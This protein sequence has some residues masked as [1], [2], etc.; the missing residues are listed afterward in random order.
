MN[1]HRSLSRRTGQPL[2]AT[3]SA[4]IQSSLGAN[5]AGAADED[6]FMKSFEDVPAV[7]LYTSRDLEQELTQIQAILN[8]KNVD[9]E[10]RSEALRKF[11]SVMVAGGLGFDNFLPILKGMECSFLSSLKDLRSKVVREACITVAYLSMK[12]GNKVERFTEALLPTLFVL[13]P[14]SAKIMS[15]SAIVC[16]RFIIQYTHGPRL[17]PV[18][19]YNMTSK[20]KDIR[21][22]TCEFLYQLLN[23]WS[24][25]SLEKH[26]GNL[27][28]A[29]K[30][31]ISDADSEARALARKAFWR[32]SDHFKHQSDVLL[33]SLDH[34][35]QKM[36]LGEQVSVSKPNNTNY[37]VNAYLTN[38]HLYKP[39]AS[40][41]NSMTR[42]VTSSNSIENL[43][44]PTSSLS[45]TV[46]RNKSGIPVFS[47]KDEKVLSR[48]M[49]A[50]FHSVSA[51]DEGAVRR[52]RARA[53]I[54]A[55]MQ[56][57]IASYVLPQNTLS[58]Q[59]LDSISSISSKI[60]S[61][62]RTGRPRHRVSQSQPNSR[63]ASPSAYLSY[64]NE[65]RGSVRV[66]RKSGIPQLMS[67]E[68]SPCSALN[69]SPP[70]FTGLERRISNGHATRDRDSS[71]TRTT[72]ET[73]S[74]ISSANLPS[75]T[76][77]ATS[78]LIAKVKMQQQHSASKPDAEADFADLF[79]VLLENMTEEESGIIRA[80]A[81]RTMC[82]LLMQQTKFF[83][84]YVE[85]II[86]RILEASKD[87]EKEVQRASEVCA[88]TA[89]AV[90]PP[91]QCARVL[92][93]VIV[94]AELP[95]NLAAIKML[96][97]LVEHHTRDA[98]QN[99]LAEIMPA[100]VQ[101]YDHAES[102]VRK[103]AVLAM[104]AIH[105]VVGDEM[106]NYLT[107]LNGSKMKLLKLYTE[108]SKAQSSGCTSPVSPS[109]HVSSYS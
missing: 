98:V 24:T 52:A 44:R 48:T 46:Y 8:D 13:I 74:G 14:N 21:K 11:R 81:L 69:T 92:K 59:R 84:N 15:T 77:A 50:R 60:G 96:T 53:A 67:R 97:K 73:D 91:E 75:F 16:I 83:K 51:I 62:E 12:L 105:N 30:K 108:R 76:A 99:L 47:P 54:A 29:I 31:G 6:M 109:S 89:A 42:S 28:E 95:M 7:V 37:L 61:P 43:R 32:F 93:S 56:P 45:S 20:A 5:A 79:K 40:R 80:Y 103:A 35:K 57:K 68:T 71:R 90:L 63:S 10:K 27:Q 88:A 1:D 55:A 3:M 86:L 94:T 58:R 72:S 34:S 65:M 19:T 101:A 87:S 39:M 78:P 102:A 25:Q 66:R 2:K 9:W 22:A 104:V 33:N 36:L 23:N 85:L 70:N 82:D 106:K 107:G 49:S 17:I 38:H 100:L 26:V 4:N 64:V 41:G 18:I